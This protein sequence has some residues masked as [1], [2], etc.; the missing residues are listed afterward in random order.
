MAAPVNDAEQCLPGISRVEPGGRWW[1]EARAV[2]AASMEALGAVLVVQDALGSDLRQALFGRAMPEFFALPLGVKRGLV[3]GPVNGY[4]GPSPGAPAYESVRIWETTNGGGVRNVGDVLWPHGNQAFCD[5]VWTFATNMLGLEKK[6]GAMIME[7]L[8]VG[9]ER[10]CSHLD[11]LNHSVRLSRY[12]VSSEAGAGMLMKSHR[13]C[14]VLSMVVQHDIE[15]LEEQAKDRSWLAVPPEPDTVAVIAGEILR[16]LSAQFVSKPKD[17]DHPPL[18]NPCDFDGYIHMA[19]TVTAGMINK[20]DLRGLEPGGP[21]WAEARA[22]VT[23]SMEAVG[24]VLVVHDALGVELR[25]RLFER[26]AP[27]F[28]A[29]PPDVKRSLVSGPIH[30]YI[31]P[32]PKAPAYES[33]RVLEVAVDGGVVRSSADVVWPHGNPAFRDTIGAFAKN[34]LDLQKTLE[35]MILEGLGVRKEHIDSHLQS[36]NYS[37]RLSRYGSLDEMGREMFMQAHK[38]CAVL[39]L[40]AQHDVDGLELQANDGSW[41]AVPAEPG[42]FAVVAGEL[43][44]VVTNGRVPA[45]VHRVRT[46]ADRERF[47]VQ[48]ES[49]P[50]YGSTVRPVDEL[51]DG[52]HRRHYNPCKFDEYVDFR[53]LGDG[54]KLSDPLKGFCGSCP[55]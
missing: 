52:D 17:D 20:V 46:P 19:S 6:V 55:E 31:G 34:M 40:L 24:A 49:R 50:K 44:T 14:T 21:V 22:A 28:F 25:R 15:G 5:T 48:F 13:D 30:G 23:A 12:G 53:F 41:F 4:I 33:A 45:N 27:E 42:T 37:V 54:R 18:Y 2:V 11:S 10:V 3:S 1:E 47:S 7:S 9:Q 36:L 38:D 26:A 43:L 29:I 35:T 51:V 39:S 8:G 16:R 32:R